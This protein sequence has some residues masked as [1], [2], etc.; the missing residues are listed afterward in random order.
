MSRAALHHSEHW[1]RSSSILPR[2]IDHRLRSSPWKS[3]HYSSA[4]VP[5][6]IVEKRT[7]ACSGNSG[8]S[9]DRFRARESRGGFLGSDHDH[10]HIVPFF[11]VLD[12]AE[13]TREDRRSSTNETS[14]APP[15]WTSTLREDRPRSQGTAF[16][17]QLC[18]SRR[19]GARSAAPTTPYPRRRYQSHHRVVLPLP[20]PPP[21][22]H[23]D[24]VS[25]RSRRVPSSGPH[26]AG[27]L[28]PRARRNPPSPL[29]PLPPR[30]PVILLAPSYPPLIS[31]PSYLVPDKTTSLSRLYR[32]PPFARPCLSSRWEVF[33]FLSIMQLLFLSAIFFFNI[34]VFLS[35][36]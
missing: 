16:E 12:A 30:D 17:P 3:S 9:I 6:S 4:R 2:R 5:S 24:T 23:H 35:Q 34:S 27:S 10:V 21:S 33:R 22:T 11:L 28:H 32:R 14:F 7:C 18:A 31:P 8:V 25:L 15:P 20:P 19:R 1:R 13:K 36:S 29:H 26:S